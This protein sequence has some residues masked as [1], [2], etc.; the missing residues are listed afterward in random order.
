MMEDADL[1][2]AKRTT[3]QKFWLFKKFVCVCVCVCV[4]A[5]VCVCSLFSRIIHSRIYVQLDRLA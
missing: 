1:N 3:D 2:F 4:R 5:R